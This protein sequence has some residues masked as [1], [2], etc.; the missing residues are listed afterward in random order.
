VRRRRRRAILCALVFA[1]TLVASHETQGGNMKWT[2]MVAVSA[3]TLA[4][5]SASGAAA[6]QSAIEKSPDVLR[7]Q[8]LKKSLARA[9]APQQLAAG[10]ITAAAAPT[11]DEVGDADSFGR[12]VTY[13]GLAQT[14]P[15]TLLDDCTG[16]DPTFERCI[17]QQPAPLSTNFDESGLAVMNLPAKA[18]KS[19]LCFTL[20][21]FI[22]I[23]W[24]NPTATQQTARF[25]ATGTII[26]DNALLDDPTLIDPTT[27]SPFNGSLSVGLS[28]WHNMHSIAPGEF[29]DESSSQTRSCIAGLVSKRALVE[30][31]GLSDAQ[32]S[33]F[34]KKAMTIHFG[35]RG[36]V[37]MS[38]FTS[39][40]YGIRLFGD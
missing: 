29:E 8:Q 35:A 36:A 40:F 20:T 37:A 14:L 10:P 21:P 31:Y 17:V 4:S 6:H 34:F 25:T 7:P 24:L 2:V 3:I 33:Q 38:Q 1:A 9:A 18:S 23:S 32:A 13:L 22:S 15:V 27:G 39:Y 28:T 30:T 12:N 16:S 26:I 5:M 19:L 11:A